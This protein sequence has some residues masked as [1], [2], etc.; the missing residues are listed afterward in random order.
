MSD[1]SKDLKLS[2]VDALNRLAGSVSA[3][4]DV[5]QGST[6]LNQTKVEIGDRQFEANVVEAADG[7]LTLIIKGVP[8]PL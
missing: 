1:I 7:T 6:E 5:V 8:K 3:V 4:R 2:L